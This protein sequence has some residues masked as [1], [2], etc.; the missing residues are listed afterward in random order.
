MGAKANTITTA[1][2]SQITPRELDFVTRFSRNWNALREI[3][4]IMR[5]VRKQPGTRLK[6]YRTTVTLH[7]GSVPEG[8]EIPY[9]T[10]TVE[11]VAYND[12]TIEKYAK[13]VTI[14]AV[15]EY[16]AEI[17]VEKT[18]DE[19]L[20]E[21]QNKVL[22]K[23]YTFLK[24][25]TLVS[26]TDNF[27]EALAAAKGN[28]LEKFASMDKDVTNTVGFVNILD[29]Y[30]YLATANITVQTKFGL[31]YIKDFMGYGT[32]FLLPT[33]YIPRGTVIAIPVENIV[34]YYIDPADSQYAKLGLEYA[35]D[36]ETNL[37]GFHT[38][39]KYSH[40]L[41]ESFAIMGMTLWA[42]YLDGI[43]IVSV[44]AHREVEN[45]TG[46]PK[47]KGYYEKSGIQYVP[48]EDTSVVT[49]KTYYEKV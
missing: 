27:Q 40:A 15:D 25:G 45:P 12:V 4:G 41:G 20:I 10:A 7:S 8:D 6:S 30:D 26:G 42:E 29:V 23:F 17:A 37:I 21:L 32:L 16:G 34:L 22:T 11:P 35:V 48:T 14:E 44:D 46:D 1:Q 39:G 47:A 28:V 31:N 9:S 24:T 5:P 43:A 19:F 2:F 36:G 33:K 38:Q 13:A 49:G 3:L 18:D